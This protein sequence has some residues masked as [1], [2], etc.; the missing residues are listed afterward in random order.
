MCPLCLSAQLNFQSYMSKQIQVGTP[1]KGVLLQHILSDLKIPL[2]YEV[3]LT[4]IT[5]FGPGDT[6]MRIIE[7]SE[8]QACGFEVEKICGFTQDKKDDFDWT[9]QNANTQNPKRSPNTGPT[10]D[11]SG[12]RE[13]YYMYIEAS[14]PRVPGDK[15]RLVSPLYNVTTKAKGPYNTPFCISFYYHMYG[16]HIGSLNVLVRVK[17]IGALDTQVWTLSGNQGP[18]WQQANITINPRGPFQVVFEGVRGSSYE[19]DIAID[20]IYVARGKCP[21]NRETMSEGKTLC[22]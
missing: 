21:M 12:T 10:K 2:S 1:Q 8:H 20:D 7:Y 6:S 11:R 3:R 18:N 16:K 9:R 15:A 22:T 5:N 4:P 13:G 17:S 19:G 14:R